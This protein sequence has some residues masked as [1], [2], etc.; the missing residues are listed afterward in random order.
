MNK[1][2]LAVLLS[3]ASCAKLNLKANEKSDKK[4]VKGVKVGMII[5]N[6]GLTV[7]FGSGKHVKNLSV[8]ERFFSK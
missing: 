3:M 4:D 6:S 1:L 2:V 5:M 8:K 7:W